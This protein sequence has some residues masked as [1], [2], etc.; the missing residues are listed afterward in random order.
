M[1]IIDNFIDQIEF[2]K[3]QTEVM[4]G[5]FIWFYNDDIDIGKN[6]P[7]RNKYP[8]V[9]NFMFTHMFYFSGV[10]RSQDC[11]ILHPI[12]EI[13]NPISL[14]RIKANLLTRTPKIVENIFHVDIANLGRYPEKLKHWTTSIFY[15]NT[16]NGYTE[17]EDGTKVESI[18]NRMIT[19]PANLKHRGTSCTDQKI[20][21][22]INFDYFI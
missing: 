7:D 4:G 10:M 19:F 9:D 3:L 21:V 6:D 2:D 8:K 20:R 22:V 5:E 12:F 13:I 1:E 18:A 14:W 16:N 17:F 11:G 15:M